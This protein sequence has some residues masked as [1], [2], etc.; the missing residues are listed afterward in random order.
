MA[1]NVRLW[2]AQRNPY[3]TFS[4]ACSWE[5]ILIWGINILDQA[6]S[7]CQCS[8]IARSLMGFI[9]PSVKAVNLPTVEHVQSSSGGTATHHRIKLLWL[10]AMG[11]AWPLETGGE[12]GGLQ[13]QR[14]AFP[15]IEG[16]FTIHLR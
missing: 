16:K 5:A 9:A 11:V 2:R 14:G 6:W 12:G 4:G 13:E 3:R 1:V 15:G 8:R 7:S 10:G